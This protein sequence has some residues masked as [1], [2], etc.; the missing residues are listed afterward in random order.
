MRRRLGG[1][2][3]L[4]VTTLAAGCSDADEPSGDASPG[5]SGSV[6]GSSGSSGSGGPGVH[7]YVDAMAE[8][9]VAQ[10]APMD[11]GQARCFS[12]GLIDVV[13]VERVED[14]GSPE[15][16][17]QRTRG[18]DYSVLDLSRKEGG[19]VYDQFDVCDVDV[20]EATLADVSQGMDKKQQRCLARV[21]TGDRVRD[22]YVT[23]MVQGPPASD[24][25]RDGRGGTSGKGGKSGRS[26]K[27]GKAG[28]A[29]KG[30]TKDRKKDRQRDLGDSALMRAMVK[31]VR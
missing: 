31:C 25:G 29:G 16:F 10:D 7:E 3:L 15:K 9:L 2:L 26:G 20:R 1:V 30:G 21:V 11:E 22:Y 28:Q 19:A 12:D 14:V 17:V 18:L 4:V 6:S 23:L 13:G 5:S 27:S 8:A 24:D